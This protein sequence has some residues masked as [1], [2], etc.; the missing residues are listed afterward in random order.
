MAD[1]KKQWGYWVRKTRWAGV[2]QVREGGYL[3]TVRV[4]DKATMSRP[5][6]TRFLP[7]ADARAAQAERERLLSGEHARHG[8]TG[9]RQTWSAFA[10]SLFESKILAREIKSAAGRE[11]WASTLK[12]YLVPAFGHMYCDEIRYAD[13]KA[14]RDKTVARWLAEGMPNKRKHPKTGKVMGP[15]VVP[16]SPRTANGWFSILRVICKAMSEV[17]E[18]HD[19]AVKLADFDTSESPVHTEERPNAVPPDKVPAFLAELKAKHRPH[20]AMAALGFVTG[21]RPSSLRPIRHKGELPDLLWEDA[22][23]L[24][25]RSNSRGAEVMETTKTGVRQRLTLPPVMMEILR[26]HVAALTPRQAKGDLLFPSR[27]GGLRSRSALDK[28]FAAAGKAL[29][30]PRVSPKA[31]RRTNKDLARA[32]DISPV[33]SKAI[34]GH[35][36]DQMHERYSTA[37]RSEIAGGLADLAA[38]VTGGQARTTPVEER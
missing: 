22:V 21:L 35:L 34:S 17:L 6:V 3:V 2:Y 19:P 12:L 4:T 8:S 16:C 1:W 24:V 28:P 15:A 38:A 7:D 14:W 30:I 26:E 9:K 27:T 36:T 25:R 11:R 20:Y 32:L 5:T 13:V 18:I 33:V 29:G 23:L 10:A 37:Q 31:M